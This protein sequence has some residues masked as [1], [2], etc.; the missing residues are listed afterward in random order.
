M[1]ALSHWNLSGDAWSAHGAKLVM[2]TV[3][4]GEVGACALLVA[5]AQRATHAAATSHVQLVRLLL[6]VQNTRLQ[7]Q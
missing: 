7:Q 3:V 2:N 6:V 4:L 5:C 1:V